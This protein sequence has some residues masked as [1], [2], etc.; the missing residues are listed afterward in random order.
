[1]RIS[2][3]LVEPSRRCQEMTS[4]MKNVLAQLMIEDESLAELISIAISLDPKGNER[5]E[6]KTV[7]MSISTLEGQKDV[8]YILYGFVLFCAH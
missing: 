7:A 3:V 4:A 5:G 8:F 1:M 2:Y 6:K